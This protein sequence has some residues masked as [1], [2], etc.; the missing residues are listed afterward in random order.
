M[1]PAERESP[2]PGSARAARVRGNPSQEKPPGP[3]ELRARAARAVDA[4]RR[5]R[6]ALDEVLG[7]GTPPLV[8]E[9]AFGTCRRYFS[10]RGAVDARL[11]HPLRDRDQDIYALL[12]VGLYQLRHLRVPDHAA[13]S[14]TVAATRVLGKPW[15][16]GLVNGVL[17]RAA[18]APADTASEE[19]RW[20]HPR[21]LIEA[22]RTAWPDL[23]PELFD[24]NNGRAPMALRVNRTKHGVPAYRALLDAAGLAHRPGIPP[25][26]LVLETP[27]PAA[28]LPGYDAGWVA[29]QDEAA[30]LAATLLPLAPE[31]RVLDACAAPGGKAFGMLEADPSIAVTAL[32]ASEN[33]LQ[34]LHGE[35]DRLGHRLPRVITGDATD[36]KWWDGTLFDAIL[37]DAPC[38]GTGTLRRHPDIKVSRTPADVERAADLQRAMLASLWGVLSSGGTLLYCTCSVLP[39]ENDAVL[40][41][42]L[43][44]TPDAASAPIHA[45]WGRSTDHGRIVLPSPG[46][47]DGFYFARVAKGPAA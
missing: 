25:A 43:A 45:S 34:R 3:A 41:D 21:W 12:L 10:L 19:E 28:R 39:E 15:A 31:A 2:Q 27:V 44:V 37:L 9:L 40:E 42:F 23:C 13:V 33:R 7:A 11:S 30:Q 16:R 29:V 32:D 1:C 36:T 22:L 20:E 8:R 4:V 17:R 18:E 46:G 6:L 14:E 35:A 47:P 38:S 24:A 26:S 5:R